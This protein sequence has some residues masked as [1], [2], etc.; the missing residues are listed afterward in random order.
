MFL[1]LTAAGESNFFVCGGEEDGEQPTW[2]GEIFVL[3]KF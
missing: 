3:L 1:G 2:S